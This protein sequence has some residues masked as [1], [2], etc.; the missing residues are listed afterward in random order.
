MLDWQNIKRLLVIAIA[1][2]E[3]IQP[4]SQRIRATL[5]D[6][7]IALLGANEDV[8]PLLTW[9]NY[10]IPYTSNW[11]DEAQEKKLVEKL[12]HLLFDAAIIFTTTESPYP[13]AYLCYLAQIPIRVGQSREFGGGV[14]SHCIKPPLDDLPSINSHLYLLDAAGLTNLPSLPIAKH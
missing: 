4:A 14:L 9:V 8:Q 6:A 10:I 5:E 1:D 7:E 2:A 3:G 11:Q 12:R 13:L